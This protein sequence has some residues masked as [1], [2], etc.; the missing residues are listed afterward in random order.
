M[1][2]LFKISEINWDENE[3]T[4]YRH[5]AVCYNGNNIL[6]IVANKTLGEWG[7]QVIPM[8]YSY[9]MDDIEFL[10]KLYKKLPY[11]MLFMERNSSMTYEEMNT[12][13]LENMSCQTQ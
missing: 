4:G 11:L 8:G 3:R 7:T 13:I 9:K 2:V 5:V 10:A 6:S 1:T 12:F